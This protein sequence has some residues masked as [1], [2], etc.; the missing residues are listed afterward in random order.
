M[1]DPD[2][3]TADVRDHYPDFQAEIN[4][5]L[6]EDLRTHGPLHIRESDA[7]PIPR[8]SACECAVT[9]RENPQ[10]PAGGQVGVDVCDLH[11][12]QLDESLPLFEVYLNAES[13]A[14][15]RDELRDPEDLRRVADRLG[16]EL[17]MQLDEFIAPLSRDLDRY[18]DLL[19]AWPDDPDLEIAVDLPHATVRG[20]AGDSAIRDAV[21]DTR[22]LIQDHL[23]TRRAQ[24]D[25]IRRKRQS[26]FNR[27][28]QT[29]EDPEVEDP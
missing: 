18:Q 2:P 28:A 4:Q 9:W 27:L 5:P 29:N 13:Q 3:E 20:R 24:A 8:D 21:E 10:H 19:D 26:I 17:E 6:M 14:R 22:D 16:T 12:D 23:D 25:R 15:A 11:D 1:T 7:V